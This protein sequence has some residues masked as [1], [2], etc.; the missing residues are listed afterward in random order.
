MSGAT[1][2]IIAS[3]GR[4]EEVTIR[5]ALDAASGSSGSSPAAPGG[6]P[7]WHRSTWTPTSER[8]VRSPVGIDIGARTAEEIALSILAEVVR[9]IRVDG[10]E[11]PKSDVDTRAARRRRSTPCAA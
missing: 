10:L 4:S 11:A 8:V 2:V 6:R 9:A 5:A 3:H 1:A 7:C